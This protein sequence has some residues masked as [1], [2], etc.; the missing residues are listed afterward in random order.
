MKYSKIF[1]AAMLISLASADEAEPEKFC[2]N[3]V[4]H[5]IEELPKTAELRTCG[6]GLNKNKPIKAWTES[7]LLKYNKENVWLNKVNHG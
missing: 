2:P 5:S 6:W 1:I 3:G 4:T 7:E